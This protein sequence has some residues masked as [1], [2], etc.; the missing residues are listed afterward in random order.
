MTAE[1]SFQYAYEQIAEHLGKA[2]ENLTEGEK[3]QARINEVVRWI[4]CGTFVDK[5]LALEQQEVDMQLALDNQG[6]NVV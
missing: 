6:Q 5:M 2:R 3:K 4:F 1:A